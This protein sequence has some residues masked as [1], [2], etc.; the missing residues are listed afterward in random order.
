MK[1]GLKNAIALW[2]LAGGALGCLG[3]VATPLRTDIRESDGSD[4][5]TADAAAGAAQDD[6]GQSVGVPGSDAAAS[7]EQ[8]SEAGSGTGDPGQDAATG[9]IT[10][11]TEPPFDDTDTA[12][13]EKCTR[14]VVIAVGNALRSVSSFDGKT[15]DHDVA[16]PTTGDQNE[17]SHRDVIVSRG[18]I[19]ITGDAGTL[20]SKDG[21]ATFQVTAQGKNH[22]GCLVAFNDKIWALGS[23]GTSSTSDGTTWQTWPSGGTKLP[24][25]LDGASACRSA[26]TGSGKILSIAARTNTWRV[27]D[28]TNW[29]ETA[30]S[31]DFG[32]LAWVTFGGGTFALVGDGT[33]GQ[34]DGLRAAGNGTSWMDATNASSGSSFRFSSVMWTGQEFF[35]TGSF[36]ATRG[37]VS[38]NGLDYTAHSMNVALGSA[39]PFNGG[40]I[41]NS[42]DALYSSSDL[43]SW[44]QVYKGTDNSSYMLIKLAS[45]RVL[46]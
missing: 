16:S 35:A 26:T 37:Y 24:G 23:S 29:F 17:N 8:G 43:T 12:L 20:T 32:S 44:T 11:P 4:A 7:G 42:V 14:P 39:V 21:G 25:G 5:A 34:F 9:P 15:W 3:T 40:Y 36:Y 18:L 2:V 13:V 46:K 1:H 33:G 31:S 27:F 38:T 30:F 6:G 10:Y 45:G 41:G 19:V 22:D 28:G